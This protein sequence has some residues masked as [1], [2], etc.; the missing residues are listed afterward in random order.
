MKHQ[1]PMHWRGHTGFTVVELLVVMS[2]IVLLVAILLPSMSLAKAHAR[3]VRCQANQ[4]QLMQAQHAY[5]AENYMA[6]AHPN[7]ASKDNGNEPGFDADY[8]GWLYKHPRKSKL[9]HLKEGA[10]WKY[11][12][13]PDVYRCVSHKKPWGGTE[14][15]TR[16]CL[17]GSLVHYGKTSDGGVKKQKYYATYRLNRW[18][19][20]DIWYWETHEDSN[21]WNDGSNYPREFATGRHPLGQLRGAGNVALVSGAVQWLS[22]DEYHDLA[23]TG[24]KNR[25]WNVT[26]TKNGR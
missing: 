7:W 15:I 19:P 24:T 11:L 21:W 1:A 3:M 10:L 8:A 23:F 17:N 2:I 26:D 5:A 6:P 14:R 13:D 4:R 18:N 9:E 22:E 12:L 25:L 16:Y 20:E